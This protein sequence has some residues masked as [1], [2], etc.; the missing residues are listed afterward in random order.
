MQLFLFRTDGLIAKDCWSSFSKAYPE[1]IAILDAHEELHNTHGLES[2]LAQ[3][4]RE[5]KKVADKLSA[6]VGFFTLF[7]HGNTIS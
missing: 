2:T 4:Q 6:M 5:F 1:W 3:R 7:I